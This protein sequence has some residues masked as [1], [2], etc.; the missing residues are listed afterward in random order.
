[1]KG[2]GKRWSITL[3]FSPIPRTDIL[4][5]TPNIHKFKNFTSPDDW[6]VIQKTILNGQW[7]SIG[8]S[9]PGDTLKFW[10]MNLN[11]NDFFT[12]HLFEKIPHG[13]WKLLRVY[14]NG[15]T[16]GQDGQFHVDSN[17]PK[18]WT[19]LLYVTDIPQDSIYSY[20]GMTVF[21]THMGNIS[22][23]PEPG[24]GV[25]FK[26]NITHKG[27]SPSCSS[28]KMRTTIAWKLEKI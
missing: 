4:F 26:S 9:K 2:S 11:S 27:I 3:F 6:T 17:D 1:M 16:Y 22:I 5:A 19:F 28:T 15:Q 10:N 24:L 18:H 23:F 21:N 8:T 20:N 7:I 12:K 14:A 25:L 13:P